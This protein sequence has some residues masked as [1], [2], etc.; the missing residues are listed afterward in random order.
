MQ[1]ASVDYSLYDII[2]GQNYGAL[3]AES[4]GCIDKKQFYLNEL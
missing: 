3:L 2:L 1:N 4:T